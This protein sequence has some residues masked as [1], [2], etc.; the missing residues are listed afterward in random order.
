[1]PICF[2]RVGR[3]EVPFIFLPSTSCLDFEDLISKG[4]KTSL[5]RA[6]F[7]PLW[8]LPAS[9][10]LLP[11]R[12]FLVWLPLAL[13]S[14]PVIPAS[15]KLDLNRFRTDAFFFG[16]LPGLGLCCT[17][18]YIFLS[19]GISILIY[20]VIYRLD[21]G[22]MGKSLGNSV[23]LLSLPPASCCW[24][25]TFSTWSWSGSGRIASSGSKPSWVSE[26]KWSNL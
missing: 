15:F 1:M 24:H 20:F 22:S 6:N 19:D 10:A 4:L 7:S 12:C 2:E 18:I 14:T 17:M 11:W 13:P 16:L 5:I 9:T 21:L 26:F 8:F 25:K 3:P 23:S